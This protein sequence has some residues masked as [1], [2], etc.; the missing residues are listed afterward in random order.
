M[1][2]E[3][4]AREV[5]TL[6]IS[7]VASSKTG[8]SLKISVDTSRVWSSETFVIG[9]GDSKGTDSD[10]ALTVSQARESSGREDVWVNGS[11]AGGI[12]FDIC[13]IQRTFQVKLEPA[14]SV[15]VA[16]FVKGLLHLRPA[17]GWKN[18]GNPEFSL[19][20]GYART[21]GLSQWRHSGIIFR[22]TRA[23]ECV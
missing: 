7:V 12:D 8:N 9:D 2:R 13:V 20:P 11:I 4:E 1:T 19:E 5:L 10:N 17:S 15:E 16:D 21:R 3:L 18:Q 23:E 6:K 14:L 22:H